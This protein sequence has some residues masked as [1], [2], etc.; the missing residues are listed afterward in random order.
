[1]NILKPTIR[2]CPTK[3]EFLNA[4]LAADSSLSHNALA[5]F[6]AQFALE[7]ATG[8]KCFNFNM[9][10]VKYNGVG[11]YCVLHGVFEFVNGKRVELGPD[12][13]GSRFRSFDTLQEGAAFFL[14]F[15]K[16]GRYA[17]AYA[18]ALTGDPAAFVHQLHEHGFFTAPESTYI[19]GVRYHFNK[20]MHET[21]YK[22]VQTHFIEP[23][24]PPMTK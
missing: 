5:V 17:T 16:G 8:A 22:P 3:Q 21:D 14:S 4:F 1:M 20:F 6:F 2:T 18:A 9:N 7:T 15:L 19:L 13:P 12:D 11:D 24:Q 10:N 23:P